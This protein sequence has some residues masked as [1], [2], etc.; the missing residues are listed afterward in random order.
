M[1]Q[2]DQDDVLLNRQHLNQILKSIKQQPT[3][4]FDYGNSGTLSDELDDFFGYVEAKNLLQRLHALDERPPTADNAIGIWIETRVDRLD[5]R[6][7][8]RLDAL[9]QLLVYA[10]AVDHPVAHMDML[11]AHNRILFNHNVFH[12]AFLA[13]RRACNQLY[14]DCQQE[15]LPASHDNTLL[16]ISRLLTLCYLVLEVNRF[17]GRF[18]ADQ[19]QLDLSYLEY[20]LG[21]LTRLKEGHMQS[22]PVK[23]L[24]LL[25]WK[26]FLCTLGD[27][28]RAKQWKPEVRLRYNL[29]PE[30]PGAPK[31]SY[32]D[33]HTFQH[34]IVS[35]YPTFAS[36]SRDSPLPSE[37]DAVVFRVTPSLHAAMGMLQA[38]QQTT[39]PYQSLFPPKQ[40]KTGGGVSERAPQALTDPDQPFTMLLPFTETGLT[41]PSA[42]VEANDVYKQNTR[43]SLSE[44]QLLQERQRAISKYKSLL[45]HQGN[46]IDQ[47][48]VHEDSQQDN[49]FTKLE[50]LYETIVPDLQGLVVVLLKTM[51]S[52]ATPRAKVNKDGPPTM[53]EA[54]VD[55]H[56]EVLC[57]S[58][59]AILLLLLKWFKLS[60][61]LKFEYLS[62]LLVDSGC[63]LLIL[64]IFGLQEVSALA[65]AQTNVEGY[66]ILDQIAH[67][68]VNG[69][70]SAATA[71]PSPP[72]ST[73]SDA[74]P[75]TN[76]RNLFWIVNLLRTLQMLTKRKV[77]RIMLL[78]QYKSAAILKRVHKIAHPTVEL[79]ALKNLKNQIPFLGRK[80]RNANMKLIS[81]V[82]FRCKTD[83][84]DDWLLVRSDKDGDLEEGKME[85]I[86]MRLLIRIYHGHRYL[87]HMLPPED[88]IY[89]NGEVVGAPA[90]LT[91]LND[92]VDE[93]DADFKANYLAWLD[94]EVYSRMDDDA[95]SNSS[96]DEPSPNSE[97]GAWIDTP[98]P[99][100]PPVSLSSSSSPWFDMQGL[101][102]EINRLYQE[103]LL[104]EFQSKDGD[105]WDAPMVAKT[106]TGEALMTDENETWRDNPLQD[107]DWNNLTSDELTERLRIVE[108][109]T[110]RRWM[111][112]DINDSRYQ[113]VIS[114]EI[115]DT[116]DTW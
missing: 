48:T 87:P 25:V 57:K 14:N 58:V 18:H 12:A 68:A 74:A 37:L 20:L 79:Y 32:Q 38:S 10:L 26:V 43:L 112:I 61:V 24:L 2:P 75:Y 88:S 35:R 85:E 94:Q 113:K 84:R 46:N 100:P 91:T 42:L 110:V 76:T 99:T 66:S 107:I 23:K 52:T 27:D 104:R 78:V 8:E 1:Q 4:Q 28:Q 60:H 45:E 7:E 41:F 55:R 36:L 97:G 111:N 103:E 89:S 80:W 21:M 15:R 5:A 70:D 72:T 56:R 47:N 59:S 9:E 95:E 105:S 39:L 50:L 49:I 51:L 86:N 34:E 83:L 31:C 33:I 13:L 19:D 44:Y 17:D 67:S 71:A 98:I 116:S 90:T 11:K 54:D 69:H 3:L 109:K 29:P 6:H 92:H 62:Q 108:E 40:V 16:E 106:A 63:M 30:D 115:E 102:Q 77:H 73:T 81:A 64:K 82:Y 22:F 93:L 101:T 53:E 96:P 114:D 65:V